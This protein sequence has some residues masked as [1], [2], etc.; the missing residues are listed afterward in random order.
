M[1]GLAV[2]SRAAMSRSCSPGVEAM[3]SLSKL[4]LQEL[5]LSPRLDITC[6]RRPNLLQASLIGTNHVPCRCCCLRFRLSNCS[7][8]SRPLW[9]MLFRVRFAL[10][11]RWITGSL[12]CPSN[13][14]KRWR[15]RRSAQQQR[16]AGR[17]ACMHD[18]WTKRESGRANATLIV[19]PL[20]PLYYDPQHPSL[21]GR[22][23]QC[24]RHPRGFADR[25]RKW[26]LLRPSFFFVCQ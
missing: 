2:M 3:R 16:F 20:F 11:F 15:Q 18:L 25:Q 8:C 23:L 9:A 6:D 17:P 5:H 1:R 26:R 22:W 13:L 4:R 19:S 24:G 7:H 10:I 12:D 21:V 14:K